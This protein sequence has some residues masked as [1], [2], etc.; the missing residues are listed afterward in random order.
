MVPLC[1]GS[2]LKA[3]YVLE[4]SPPI[5][6]PIFGFWSYLI[7]IENT[8]VW[9]GQ[10]ICVQSAKKAQT[11][12]SFACFN[13]NNFSKLQTRWLYFAIP[14]SNVMLHFAPCP[15]DAQRNS[16]VTP[17]NLQFVTAWPQFA[18]VIRVIAP[19]CLRY[20]STL[21]HFRTF[22]PPCIYSFSHCEP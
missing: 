5:F 19:L 10:V 2:S 22:F 20:R 21:N 8:Q 7:I 12:F 9:P 1:S 13:L 4:L 16:K 17:E 11:S 14:L 6:S 15:S 3:L 18:R